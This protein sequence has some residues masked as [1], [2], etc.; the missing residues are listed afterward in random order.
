MQLTELAH[1][2]TH[3]SGSDGLQIAMKSAQIINTK[4]STSYHIYVVRRR[5]EKEGGWRTKDAV[6]VELRMAGVLVDIAA[7]FTW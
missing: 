7:S 6:E 1:D 5:D 4:H 2:A 3:D